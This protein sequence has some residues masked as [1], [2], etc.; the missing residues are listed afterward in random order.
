MALTYT[1]AAVPLT[2][3]LDTASEFNQVTIAADTTIVIP[4]P[5]AGAGIRNRHVVI[6]T[7]TTNTVGGYNINWDAE[8]LPVLWEDNNIPDTIGQFAD[9]NTDSMYVELWENEI[10]TGWLGRFN[11]HTDT[12]L[13]T[14]V[15]S[16]GSP[17]TFAPHESSR[18]CTQ[19]D[20]TFWSAP[21]SPWSG[22]EWVS[23]NSN[24]ILTAIGVWS[25]NLAQFTTL[26]LLL[27]LDTTLIN[28][29][30]FEILVHGDGQLMADISI[31]TGLAAGEHDFVIPLFYTTAGVRPDQISI[32]TTTSPFQITCIDFNN[33]S[34]FGE[35]PSPAG[36]SEE[37]GGR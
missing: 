10:G 15:S 24:T 34:G 35:D 16:G 33:T 25:D 28:G 1:P 9:A 30:A 31:D 26:R 19:L 22:T 3:P 8:G 5:T 13:L 17:Y 21:S 32:E 18:D 36:S 11:L 29:T 6:I 12:A 20:D 2:L 37:G 7:T 4:T 14:P 23:A 27:S